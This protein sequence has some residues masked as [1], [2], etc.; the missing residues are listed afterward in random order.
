MND[1]ARRVE[2][3]VREQSIGSLDVQPEFDQPK[4]ARQSCGQVRFSRLSS[5][6]VIVALLWLL[7]ACGPSSSGTGASSG[8]SSQAALAIALEYQ[9][10]N[11]L[12]AAQSSLAALNAPN[13]NQLLVLVTETA[14][15]DGDVTNA[16]ALVR[17]TMA[18]GLNS[19]AID[20]YAQS[21]GF[22]ASQ[23]IDTQAVEQAAP[24]TEQ[25]QPTPIPVAENPTPI[26][27]EATATT[28][29]PTLEAPTP[30][31][32]VPTATP[33]SDP[34]IRSQS[35]MNVRGGPGTDYA[36]VGALNAGDGARIT[37]KNSGGDWW[38]ISLAGGVTGWVYGPLVDITGNTESV[39][40]A[41]APPP[42]PV[43]PTATP[44]PAQPTNTPV[45]APA[46]VDFRL[47]EQ[48]IWGVEENGGHYAGDSINCGDKQELHV[49]VLDAAGN[50]LNGVTVRG[51]Y[52]NEYHVT[53]EKGPGMAQYDV[54]VDGDDIV[55]A[56]DVDGREVSSDLA[57]G[58]TAKTFN[59]S[60][61]F[62]MQGGFCKDD[63]SCEVFK[64]IPG[65][66]G[67]F[68]WTVTFQRTY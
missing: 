46:G 20:R 67:H 63:A 27:Q 11:D 37:G 35:A 41:E 2:S 16:D 55:V 22:A 50:R 13:T 59:I 44:A 12:A 42:P 68:S 9:S 36:V 62:L 45:P 4:C 7:A 26:P 56:K 17:L 65:C 61:A 21:R 32:E 3:S 28:E 18:F 60:N 31:P 52:R 10:T 66:Y 38:Q 23:A 24:Q 40:L 48:R 5:L 49:I 51:V 53:G 8:D 57:K 34:E 15:R 30:T 58:L 43:A 1:M 33:P 64:A 29:P 25:T 39:A 6:L 14:I 19:S 54:N 47:V